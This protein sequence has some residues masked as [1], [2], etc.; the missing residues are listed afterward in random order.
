M[1][2]T[3]ADVGAAEAERKINGKP[4]TADITL[5]LDDL[6]EGTAKVAFTA[7]EKEKLA[8]LKPYTLPAAS[9]GTLG[10]VRVGAGLSID[11]NG[12]LSATTASGDVPGDMVRAVY[13]PDGD[14]V[15]H[16][17]DE[18][19]AVDWGNVRNRPEIPAALA[20]LNEDSMHRTVT[21]GEKAVWNAKSSLALGETAESAY[22]GDRGKVA[23]DHSQQ[24]GNP[25]GT[26]PA[27][28]G[29]AAET[30]V[31]TNLS[32]NGKVLSRDVAITASD[33]GAA[34]MAHTHGNITS[35]GK[36]GSASNRA[37]YTGTNG[38]LQAGTLPVSAGGTGATT[39]S[40]ARSALGAAALS[41]THTASDVSGL[42]ELLGQAVKMEMGSYVGTGT[43]GVSNPNSLT[44][45]FPPKF[46]WIYGYV[47]TEGAGR[48]LAPTASYHTWMHPPLLSTSYSKNAFFGDISKT[49]NY[50][51]KR[52]ED[53]KTIYWY[54]EASAIA[55]FNSGNR[56]YLYLAFS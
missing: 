10:G 40:A 45:E 12:V 30:H 54:L 8:G 4:L 43:Y 36:I 46:V 42:A 3:A 35:D 47:D 15:V 7:A 50:Y 27:D 16:A 24:A 49:L 11:A 48:L 33:V 41:H 13:D 29:A 37:V 34:A 53:G 28:I 38:L 17:A 44:F 39:A 56:V 21:D 20:D 1:T 18:A 55:Q 32:I 25:H 2:L 19:Y 6:P 26:T 52:S 9:A 14:G 51:G 23:Y 31:H 5:T 22:R